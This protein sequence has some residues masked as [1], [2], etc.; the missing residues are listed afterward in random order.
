MVGPP[1]GKN[2]RVS[3]SA[4]E[5]LVKET[6]WQIRLLIIYFHPCV[7]SLSARSALL[8]YPGLFGPYYVNTHFLF[9]SEAEA[10]ELLT[11]IEQAAKS[12]CISLRQSVLL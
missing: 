3:W 4:P 11:S 1:P 12:R 10:N 8:V 5:A 6:K 9:G 7:K 2:S